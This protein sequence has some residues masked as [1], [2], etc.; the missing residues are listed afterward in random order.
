MAEDALTFS[1]LRKIQKRESRQD[2]L[3]ELDDDFVLKVADYLETKKEVSGESRE[4]R[5]AKRV[6][7]KIIGL[8]EEK[9]VKNA[10][11]A[12]KSGV[13]ASELN[14][15][16]TEKQLFLDMKTEFGSHHERLDDRLDSGMVETPDL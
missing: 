5:N 2:E 6:F 9:I 4:Y 1:E 10:R 15:L 14:L 11:L 3:T 16:P 8:R 7:D 12:V 13:D